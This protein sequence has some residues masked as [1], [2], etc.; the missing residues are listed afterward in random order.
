MLKGRN[1][2][3]EVARP[4]LGWPLRSPLRLIMVIAGVVL[5]GVVISQLRSS[6]APMPTAD[7]DQE[8]VSASAAPGDEAGHTADL[9]DEDDLAAVWTAAPDDEEAGH[10]AELVE[11]TE[12][13]EETGGE[14]V[15][16]LVEGEPT[17]DAENGTDNGHDH[18]DDASWEPVE[19]GDPLPVFDPEGETEEEIA[20]VAVDAA[21]AMTRPA[22]DAD[23]E[24]WW[25]E[26]SPHLTE[27]A[28][29]DY[30]GTDPQQVPWT[31]VDTETGGKMLPRPADTPE[32][33]RLVQ[34][35]TDTGPVTVWV[36]REGDRW[37]VSRISWTDIWSPGE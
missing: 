8:Q 5:A 32:L 20:A 31:E 33:L 3:W 29:G 9:E 25:E 11:G 28:A 12:A 4:L 14:P 18:G 15:E 10:T 24:Q 16:D 26:F 37:A 6:E 22:E 2:L 23:P 19:P 7:A 1:V 30:E 34:V 21:V 36:Q 17:G 35:E 13:A 27:R